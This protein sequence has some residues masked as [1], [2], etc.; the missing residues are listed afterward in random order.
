MQKISGIV[1]DTS[2]LSMAARLE[3]GKTPKPVSKPQEA[4]IVSDDFITRVTPVIGV[5]LEKLTAMLDKP[6]ELR[7]K[8]QTEIRWLQLL[9]IPASSHLS[10]AR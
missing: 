3:S 9:N 5:S 7:V 4:L 2:L 8:R 6:N 1:V 10:E